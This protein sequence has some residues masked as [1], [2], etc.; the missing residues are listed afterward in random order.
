VA[1]AA[2]QNLEEIAGVN[3]SQQLI[4]MLSYQHAYQASADV[5]NTANQMLQSLIQAV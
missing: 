2:Q 1:T 4:A 3:T 5:V